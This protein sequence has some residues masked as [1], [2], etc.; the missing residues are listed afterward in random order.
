VPSTREN[1]FIESMEMVAPV[2]DPV[3]EKQ[4]TLDP[5][6]REGR[7]LLPVVS[8]LQGAPGQALP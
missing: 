2:P 3:P 5:S 7:L 8:A 1:P 4:I 6:G